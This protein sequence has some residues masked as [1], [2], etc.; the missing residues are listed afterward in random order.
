MQAAFL[1]SIRKGAAQAEKKAL[2]R[3]L[4]SASKLV[5]HVKKRMSSSSSS[6]LYIKNV[7]GLNKM[8]FRIV[9]VS[10]LVSDQELIKIGKCSRFR[11]SRPCCIRKPGC[12]SLAEGIFATSFPWFSDRVIR[13]SSARRHVKFEMGSTQ[14]ARKWRRKE[15]PEFL[16]DFLINDLILSL[17]GSPVGPSANAHHSQSLLSNCHFTRDTCQFYVFALD[18]CTIVD[19]GRVCLGQFQ[20]G[21][22]PQYGFYMFLY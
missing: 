18:E 22:D 16:C 13:N 20:L 4:F 1:F 10:S 3:I 12:V 17:F 9:I 6:L 15:T 19:R 21:N 2:P 5:S 8:K 7:A 11:A 14:P